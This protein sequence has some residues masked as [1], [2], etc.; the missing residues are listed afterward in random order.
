METFFQHN[1]HYKKTDVIFVQEF[2]PHPS[3]SRLTCVCHRRS[4]LKFYVCLR[5]YLTNYNPTKE[6]VGLPG[7]PVG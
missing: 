5:A 1:T 2:Y 3:Q 4:I 6:Q 7:Y